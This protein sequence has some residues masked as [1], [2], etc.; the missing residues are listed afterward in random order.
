[1]KNDILQQSIYAGVVALVAVFSLV[2]VTSGGYEA[3]ERSASMH[4]ADT[5]AF[6]DIAGNLEARAA[7]VWDISR[8]EPL[9]VLNDEA[10]L[11]LASLTKLM[12]A[13]T[14]RRLY[15]TDA[16][17]RVPARAI[18]EEGDSGL[19]AEE[20]WPLSS[21]SRF[22]L[23]TSSND[24][25]AAIAATIGFS[26]HATS[27]YQKNV[28]AFVSHMNTYARE[29]GL[30]QTFFLN[31]SGLDTHTAISG[32]YG[33]ARD[34]ALLF[35]SVVRDAPD[36]LSMTA[37]REAVFFSDSGNAHEGENTN[38]FVADIPGL[39]GSKTGFT[40]LAEG[41]LAVVF[42][43]APVHPIA[44][45]VLGSAREGRFLDVERLVHATIQQY[46][47]AGAQD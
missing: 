38:E 22:T 23:L 28:R 24:G 29:M 12:T 31:P 25:A 4:E 11:P 26:N 13:Y 16:H 10:Q 30:A 18:Y 17:V 37:K 15:G 41:N 1:M 42:E 9:Y 8:G 27:T 40:D 2:W 20:Q 32:A 36:L 44:V 33:S 19:L 21:L 6:S 45:V 46:M 34:V 39:I 7:V 3:Q 47:N 5:D 14:A 35:G 43:F